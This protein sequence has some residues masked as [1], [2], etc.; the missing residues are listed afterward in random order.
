[1]AVNKKDAEFVKNSLEELKVQLDNIK[2][3]LETKPWM[4]VEDEN[5]QQREFK[6]QTSL[7]DSQLKYIEKYMELSGIVDFYNESQLNKESKLMKGFSE[8]PMMDILKEGKV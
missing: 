1:M 6:F 8:N 2:V 7:F 5:K 3:Y 4:G